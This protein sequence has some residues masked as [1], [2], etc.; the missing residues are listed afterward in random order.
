MDGFRESPGSARHDPGDPCPGCISQVPPARR[1]SNSTPGTSSA[2]PATLAFPSAI[3]SSA[4]TM[5]I[6]VTKSGGAARHNRPGLGHALTHPDRRTQA[7]I[8]FASGG[9]MRRDEVGEDGRHQQQGQDGRWKQ[10][11]LPQAMQH[12]RCPVGRAAFRSFQYDYGHVH[13][14]RR[15]RPGLS[16]RLGVERELRAT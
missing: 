7:V 4:S 1:N 14:T 12:V 11:Q 15:A 3:S 2:P 16:F 9:R 8:Q 5:L 13:S 6:C 10:R